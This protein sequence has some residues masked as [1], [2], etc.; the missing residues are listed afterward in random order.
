MV[1][2]GY[3]RWSSPRKMS[4]RQIQELIKKMKHD[5]N[6]LPKIEKK[7]KHVSQNDWTIA[8]QQLNAFL[9]S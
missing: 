4:Q 7:A 3:S 8:E 6:L 2:V 5:R 9:N 1:E